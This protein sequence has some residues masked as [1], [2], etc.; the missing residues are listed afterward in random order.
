MNY[1]VIGYIFLT[2]FHPIKFVE[3]KSSSSS[4]LVAEP[5]DKCLSMKP[6][7]SKHSTA[8]RKPLAINL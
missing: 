6:S 2:L 3:L 4:L 8:L 7:I 5:D 1:T